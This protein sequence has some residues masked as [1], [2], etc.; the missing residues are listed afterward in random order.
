MGQYSGQTGSG[1]NLGTVNI[2]ED[3]RGSGSDEAGK[4]FSGGDLGTLNVGGSIIGDQ[5]DFGGLF[6][7][8]IGQLSTRGDF[9]NLIGQI[10]A[11][12]TIGTVKI[13]DDLEGGSGSSSAQIQG[14][15]IKKVTIDGDIEGNGD[16]SAS[17]IAFEG[18]I[19]SIL[20]DGDVQAD[21]SF[22]SAWIVAAD[23]IS[24]VT[25]QTLL[26]A[27]ESRAT[28]IAG[29]H[30]GKVTIA[31]RTDRAD[32]LAGYDIFNPI[33]RDASIGTVIVGIGEGA[34]TITDTN[35]VAGATTGEGQTDDFTF[36]TF[37]DF[38]IGLFDSGEF[39]D[40]VLSKIS[41]VIINGGVIVG[42]E[43][44]RIFGIVAEHVGSVKIGSQ[45]LSL[46]KGGHNDYLSA[47]GSADPNEAPDGDVFVNEMEFWFNVS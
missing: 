37:D 27:S 23:S 44:G 41:K 28:I 6:N 9:I 12:G 42:P 32:I 33:N 1:D 5:G 25:A 40:R 29:N 21:D 2:E 16:F 4:I 10:S 31:D 11:R 26:G 35:I 13:G 20:V 47:T 7:D 45:K 43:P 15:A 39:D 30:I 24:S 19:G 46:H 38:P 17:I 8:F 14:A 22:G 36:G 3:V 18:S 34:G